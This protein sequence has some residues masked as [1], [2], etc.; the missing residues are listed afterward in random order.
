MK[1]QELRI[2]NWVNRLPTKG[3]PPMQLCEKTLGTILSSD[4]YIKTLEPIPLTE[5]WLLKF[6]FE[7]IEEAH[8]YFDKHHAV[9]LW[10]SGTIDFH[11]FCTNDEDCQI[12]LKHVHSLQNLYFA[13][14][15][16]E[17]T[18]KK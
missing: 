18:I 13:L 8:G 15:G 9:Y 14:T 17:L 5:E 4:F 16:E 11:P 3:I 1:A 10:A 2:G 12:E 7:W 6:G